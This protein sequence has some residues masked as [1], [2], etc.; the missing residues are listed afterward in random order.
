[1]ERTTGWPASDW[2]PPCR[3]RFLYPRP[4][5][6][7]DKRE[8]GREDI[9]SVYRGG[10]L[11]S[12]PGRRRGGVSGVSVPPV[13]LRRGVELQNRRIYHDKR[14]WRAGFLVLPHLLLETRGVGFIIDVCEKGNLN[15]TVAYNQVFLC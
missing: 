2:L 14:T 9:E 12:S 10:C 1:M 15:V 13:G 8:E 11:G 3:V 6:E 7:R 5:L 4:T